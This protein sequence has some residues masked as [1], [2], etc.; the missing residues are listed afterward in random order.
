MPNDQATNLAQSG[1][2]IRQRY[3]PH[4]LRLA[5]HWLKIIHTILAK[6]DCPGRLIGHGNSKTSHIDTLIQ[7]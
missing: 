7:K 1:D 2:L 5:Q 3:S 4:E 6:E